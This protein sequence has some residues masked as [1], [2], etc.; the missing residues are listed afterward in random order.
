MFQMPALEH[1]HAPV[2]IKL[3]YEKKEN[4]GQSH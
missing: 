3:F 4:V 2:D 1:F